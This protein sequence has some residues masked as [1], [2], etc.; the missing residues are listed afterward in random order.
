MPVRIRQSLNIE[1]GLN[2][3]LAMPFLLLAIAMANAVE[4]P[5]GHISDWLL[6]AA[7]QIIFGVVAGVVVYLLVLRLSG[8]RLSSLWAPTRAKS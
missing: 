1:S 5:L 7:S 2:D 8:M 3:G 4:S 6:F